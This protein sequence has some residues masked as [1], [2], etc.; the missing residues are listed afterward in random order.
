MIS[1]IKQLLRTV[2]LG[3]AGYLKRMGEVE[4]VWRDL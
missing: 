3:F 1:L 2:G 4:V